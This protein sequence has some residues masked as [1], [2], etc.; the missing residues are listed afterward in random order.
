MA[1]FDPV[2]VELIFFREAGA[3]LVCGT[4]ADESDA[5]FLPKSQVSL[6]R[7]IGQDGGYP[8][9]EIEMPQWLAEKEKLDFEPA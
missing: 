1:R 4:E 2:S 6:G 5:V 3:S 8:I 7:E 9:Y